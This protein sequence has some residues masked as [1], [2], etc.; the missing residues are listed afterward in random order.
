MGR[1]KIKEDGVW[2]KTAW[3]DEV[4]SLA[5]NGRIA[6]T[7]KGNADK[8]GSLDA[9]LEEN[10]QDLAQHKLEKSL[11]PPNVSIYWLDTSHE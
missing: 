11:T 2:R 4:D 9:R 5:G 1:F 10:E 3:K 6:E 7:V 8:I